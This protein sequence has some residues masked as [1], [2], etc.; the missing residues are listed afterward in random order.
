LRVR[1]RFCGSGMVYRYFFGIRLEFRGCALHSPLAAEMDE[2][3]APLDERLETLRRA[4][5]EKL[6]GLSPELRLPPL[7]EG[8]ADPDEDW[9]FDSRRDY[10][11][12]LSHYKAR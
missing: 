7:P 5:G 9:L 10:R 3:L 1:L 2:E 4:V 12:Q 8:E 11:E 6:E